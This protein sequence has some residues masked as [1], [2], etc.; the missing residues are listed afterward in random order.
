MS[1]ERVIHHLVVYECIG[2]AL[3]IMLRWLNELAIL[4]TVIFGVPARSN[5]HEALMESGAIIIAAIPTV[6]LTRRLG[7][8]LVYL[9]KFLRLAELMQLSFRQIGYW[10]SISCIELRRFELH[11]SASVPGAA[12]S[13]STDGGC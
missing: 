11:E 2:F 7:K 10:P 8:R 1:Q 5:P 9:E 6:I 13:I 12:E 3:L 4:P